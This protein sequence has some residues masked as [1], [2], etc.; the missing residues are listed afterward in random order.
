MLILI[1][2]ESFLESLITMRLSPFIG[3]LALSLS[4]CADSGG[5]RSATIDA[6]PFAEL[7]TADCQDI[8]AT[9][10]EAVAA[11]AEAKQV[12]QGDDGGA[13]AGIIAGVATGFIPIPGLGLLRRAATAAAEA[14]EPEETPAAAESRALYDAAQTTYREKG[15]GDSAERPPGS[16]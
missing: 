6:T 9:M 2:N 13:A 1:G 5:D 4:A 11:R 15:C 10:R 7:E 8:R 16:S 14:T 3:A 12:E